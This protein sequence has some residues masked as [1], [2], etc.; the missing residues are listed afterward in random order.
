MYT[1][2]EF[3]PIPTLPTE[4]LHMFGSLCPHLMGLVNLSKKLTLDKYQT[5]VI[6]IYIEPLFINCQLVLGGSCP[7]A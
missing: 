2:V 4:F 5:N 7:Q 3:G 1:F 6:L